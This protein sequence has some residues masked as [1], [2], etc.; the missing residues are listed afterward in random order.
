MPMCMARFQFAA[1]LDSDQ[2]RAQL[3]RE[4]GARRASP[5]NVE[6]EWGPSA[7]GPGGE[8]MVLSMDAIALTYAAK[9]SLALGGARVTAD[10]A[11]WVVPTWAAPRWVDLPWRRRIRIWIGPTRC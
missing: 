3:Q 7:A 6:L 1:P 5:R 2:W 9:V 11:P 10:G 4:V 8:L